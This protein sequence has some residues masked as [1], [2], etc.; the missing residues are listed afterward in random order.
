MLKIEVVET[1]EVLRMRMD[2]VDLKLQ[3][4]LLTSI[5]P[6]DQI[7]LIG[8]PYKVLDTRVSTATLFGSRPAI[9]WRF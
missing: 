4:A 2:E 8:P 5:Q 9:V 3:I 6:H 1:G 7:L